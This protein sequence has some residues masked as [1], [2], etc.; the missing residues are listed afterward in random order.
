M[1]IGYSINYF[2]YN[3]SNNIFIKEG[4]VSIMNDTSKT[5]NVILNEIGDL[6]LGLYPINEQ[7]QE[8][9]KKK[10]NKSKNKEDQ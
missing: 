3:I 7:D 2:N 10:E 1:N 6:G 5:Q 8:K 4:G 9:I